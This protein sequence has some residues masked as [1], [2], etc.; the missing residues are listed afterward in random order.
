[1]SLKILI[2][3]NILQKSHAASFFFL[4]SEKSQMKDRNETPWEHP[5]VSFISSQMSIIHVYLFHLEYPRK[6]LE[7]DGK[8]LAKHLRNRGRPTE[9]TWRKY[10]E[11]KAARKNKGL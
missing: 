5:P 11:S 2:P 10:K 4:M 9:T 3:F 7:N 6:I 1:M 8:K